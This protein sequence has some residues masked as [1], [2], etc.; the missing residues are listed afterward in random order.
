MTM[1]VEVSIVGYDRQTERLAVEH[2][3]PPAA[4]T[5][6][7]LIANVPPTDPDLIGAYPLTEEQA[8]QIAEVANISIEPA[9]FDYFLE[10]HAPEC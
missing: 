1:D 4:V 2:P 7:M 9:Q 5:A 8:R 6:A 10:A 3:V